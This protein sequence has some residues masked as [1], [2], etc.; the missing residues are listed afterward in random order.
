MTFVLPG[1]NNLRTALAGEIARTCRNGAS[2]PP[3]FQ[4]LSIRVCEYTF[5]MLILLLGVGIAHAAD[6][7]KIVLLDSKD[8]HA[9]HGK[10]VCISYSTGNP[11]DPIKQL[12]RE[13]H[14]TDSGGSAAFRL[15]D[16]VPVKVTVVLGS[17][18]LVPCFASATFAVADAM[19]VGMVA[20]NTCGDAG[21]ETTQTGELVL[22]AHQKGLWEALKE[23]RD[24]D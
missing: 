2:V 14:R 21:T 1:I 12:S 3:A 18:G 7:L 20:K 8:G 22:F 11:A 17:A 23:K 5:V 24:Q 6:D 4:P 16:P 9:L 15:S 13:C 19:K 10:L